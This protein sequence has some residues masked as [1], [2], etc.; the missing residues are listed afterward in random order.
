MTLVAL[1]RLLREHGWALLRQESS[2][3]VYANDHGRRLVIATHGQRIS[4]PAWWVH[5]ELRRLRPQ[6]P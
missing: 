2:H 6:T 1:E 3:R 4:T 5:R